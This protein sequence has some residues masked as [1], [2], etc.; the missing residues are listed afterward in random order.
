[1]SI[2]SHTPGFQVMVSADTFDM[3][4][5]VTYVLLVSYSKQILLKMHPASMSLL[6]VL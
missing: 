6:G 5:K 1:M 3:E 2:E 4:Y